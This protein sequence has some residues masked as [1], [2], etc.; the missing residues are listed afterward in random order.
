MGSSKTQKKSPFSP[1]NATPRVDES[2]EQGYFDIHSQS[3]MICSA[4]YQEEIG[5]Y[6]DEVTPMVCIMVGTFPAFS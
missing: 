6:E 3:S 5:R 4:P 1:F 2:S